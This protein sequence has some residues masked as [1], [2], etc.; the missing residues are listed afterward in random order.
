MSRDIGKLPI[1]RGCLP[2]SELIWDFKSE[3]ITQL[4]V[5]LPE[6]ETKFEP[7][8]RFFTSPLLHPAFCL[9]PLPQGV[10]LRLP[11]TLLAN[12]TPG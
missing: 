12:R 4:S 7:P 8:K 9:Y 10:E 2:K 6:S 11:S 5:A 1:P 3:L